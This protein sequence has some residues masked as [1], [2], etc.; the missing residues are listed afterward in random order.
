[1]SY[2]YEWGSKPSRYKIT[3]IVK[4]LPNGNSCK[5][6]NFGDEV[7]FVPFKAIL[8]GDRIANYFIQ[9]IKK[10]IS[11]K[12]SNYRIG[13]YSVQYETD[14]AYLTQIKGGKFGDEYYWVPKSVVNN[15]G[16]ITKYFAEKSLLPALKKNLETQEKERQRLAK[17]RT[18]DDFIGEEKST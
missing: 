3:H 16:Y 5:V 7:V 1:M 17:T 15:K 18:I 2:D 8:P 10:Q 12:Y 6:T 11:S 14:R 13:E 9:N 4:K